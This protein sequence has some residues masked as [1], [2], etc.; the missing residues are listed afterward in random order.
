MERDVVGSH[1]AVVAHPASTVV[2]RVAIQQRVTGNLFVTFAT[3][4]TQ[5]ENTTIKLEY[6][7]SPKVSFSGTRNQN[8]GF[9]FDT[10]IHKSW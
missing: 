4:V 5:T 10:K 6:Q 7:I 2:A 8:G 9:G 1:S 3:D